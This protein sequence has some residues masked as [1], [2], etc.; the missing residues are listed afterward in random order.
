MKI[1]SIIFLVLLINLPEIF[2]QIKIH[3]TINSGDGLINSQVRNIY[4]DSKGYIWF[5]TNGG[6]SKWDGKYFENFSEANG[7]TSSAVFDVTEDHNG[8][9]YLATFGGNGITTYK[10]GKLDTIFSEGNQKL[11]FVTVVHTGKDSSIYFG[12]ADGIHLYKNKTL[13]NLNNLFNIHASSYHDIKETSKGEIY[14]ATR[15]GLLKYSGNKL[16]IEYGYDGGNNDFVNFVGIDR[17]DKIYFTDENKFFVKFGNKL[18][19]VN[20]KLNYLSDKISDMYFDENNI[21]YIASD[22]GLGIFNSV[23]NSIEFNTKE[24]GLSNNNL[25]FIRALKNKTLLIS[26]SISDV[27]IYQPG[28]FENYLFDNNLLTNNVLNFCLTQDG[29]QIINTSG[30]L[31]IKNKSNNRI[32]TDQYGYGY[33]QFISLLV[34]N[35]KTF[36]GTSTGVQYYENNKINNLIVFDQTRNVMHD[37]ANS[38]FTLTSF[39][40]STIYAG[41]Y[42]GVYKIVNDQFTILNQKDGLLSGFVS[43]I[44]VTED[45]SIVYGY[46][47]KGLSIYKNQKFTH[48]TVNNGLS[49]NEIVDLCELEDGSILIGTKQNG[50]N[51][52]KNEISDTISINEGL[53]S[54]EIRSITKG[55][56]GS[57]FVTTPNGLNIL[58]FI[59]GKLQVRTL[60]KLDGLA[61][62]DCNKNALFIDSKNNIWIGTTSGLSKYN[63]SYDIEITSPPKI[64]LTGFEIFN[65]S[66]SI[67]EL[68]KNS[69]LNY[70]QN[71]LKFIY[72]GLDIPNTHKILYKYRLS[73]VD[74][75]WVT[76]NDNSVQYTSLYDGNYTFEVKARN[77]WG[78]WSE[79]TSLSFVINP[80]W[81]ETWW[82]YTLAFIAISSLIAFI[83]SYR[84]RQLL[85]VEKIR[86]KISADLHDSIGS[87]LSEI[88]ILSEILNGQSNA[89]IDDLQNGLKSISV[90]ARSLVGNMSDIVWLVNPAKDSLKDLLLRLQ[91]SYQEVFAQTNISFKLNGIENLDSIHLPLTYR[92]HL[93]LLFKEAINNSLKYS[94]CTKIDLTIDVKRKILSINYQENGK[95]FDPK[96]K[97]ESGNGLKNMRNR[98]KSIGGNC[99]IISDINKGTKIIFIGKIKI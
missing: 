14:F 54:N 29:T 58:R 61:G 46:H 51:I 11:T 17:D 74:K 91:D 70:D 19:E 5:S 48:F 28:K 96:S 60:K 36:L 40:D 64:Y 97:E 26:S 88:T 39:D 80:A 9:I 35:G 68:N 65:E 92:Q 59:E 43:K 4:E 93:F 90:T 55:K 27:F 50:L 53:S 8:T 77:E 38:V 72:T 25:L 95:G 22:I 30:G 20:P 41:T 10:N 13:I 89:K 31:L 83:A 52:L 16:T 23:T 86:T 37:Y 34:K 75:D 21:G 18:T 81:W 98:A 56:N 57:I 15:E 87:G 49:D 76:S 32:I 94:E 69:E 67:E 62:N 45:K 73:G 99:E 82:F 84:Y 12:A 78:Y 71:Y 63:P 6:V 79:P 24:N 1:F 47:G 33:N 2:A 44:L 85:E 42:K 7:L 3:K 66:Y